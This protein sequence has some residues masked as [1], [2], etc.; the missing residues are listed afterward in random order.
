MEE[1]YHQKL[2]RLIAGY[3]RG[4]EKVYKN[5]LEISLGSLK[6]SRYL[7]G[8]CYKEGFIPSDDY[9]QLISQADEIV[10]MLLGTLRNL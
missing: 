3:S 10:A 7:I 8:F 9:K 5:F 2:G 4:R 1:N 6:E